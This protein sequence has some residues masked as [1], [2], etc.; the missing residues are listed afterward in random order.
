MNRL[1]SRNYSR[2]KGII[3]EGLMAIL[4]P[5]RK[6]GLRFFSR[7][8]AWYLMATLAERFLKL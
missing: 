7:H 5:I 3:S 1:N 2:I 6:K 8:R 4:V